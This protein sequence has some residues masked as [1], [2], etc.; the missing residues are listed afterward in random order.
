[1]LKLVTEKKET[2][3]KGKHFILH[4]QIFNIENKF[5]FKIGFIGFILLVKF[6]GKVNSYI[7]ET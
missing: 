3:G 2:C 5:Q 1:M 7:E 6:Q 4:W